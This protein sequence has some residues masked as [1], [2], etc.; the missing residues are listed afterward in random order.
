MFNTGIAGCVAA[1]ALAGASLAAC[2]SSKES[3][4]TTNTTSGGKTHRVAYFM[5]TQANSFVQAEFKGMKDEGAAH[6]VQVQPFD[7]AGDPAQQ[8]AQIQNAMTSGR[9]DGFF[10]EGISN[11][12]IYPVKAAIRKGIKV[13]TVN[14]PLGPDQASG[15]AQIPGQVAAVLT[16]ASTDGDHVGQLVVGACGTK[17]CKVG[18][19]V[20][21]SDIPSEQAKIAAIKQAIAG[22][23]NIQIVGAPGQGKF[24][25]AAAITAT[26]NLL[27]S[28]PG[29]NVIATTGDDMAVGAKQ[30]LTQRHKDDVQVIGG[31]ASAPGVAAVKAGKWY[32]TT[33]K[34]PLT[35]GRLAMRA[36]EAAL[37]GDARR[38]QAIDPL[39]GAK[40]GPFVTKAALAHDPS[41][42]GE[43]QG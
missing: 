29:I 38:G 5:L 19:I 2:G 21:G 30:V 36:M 11:A 33:T 35:E 34:L 12:A 31:A 26:Q 9:F 42:A 3:T 32:G 18:L 15:K 28:Q 37:D 1:C 20:G 10:V 8:A 16:A 39:Q 25:H 22:H 41:F 7:G 23:S 4:S 13:V 43:W 24:T 6:G 40:I 14:F 27:Q 17:P